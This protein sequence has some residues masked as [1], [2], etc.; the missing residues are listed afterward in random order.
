MNPL[1]I[2]LIAAAIV[3]VAAIVLYNWFQERK[4]RK[5]SREMFESQQ[6]VLLDEQPNAEYNAERIEPYL[7]ERPV[8]PAGF[9]PDTTSRLDTAVEHTAASVPQ[10]AMNYQ[11]DAPRVSQPAQ[12]SIKA[13]STQ[14][15]AASVVSAE[16]PP[17]P[18][19]PEIDFEIRIHTADA[20]PGSAMTQL[21]E[22][23]RS[24]GKPVY[25]LGYSHLAGAWEEIAGWREDAYTEIAIAVQLA[26]RNGAVS[27]EHLMQMCTLARQLASR[28]NGIAECPDISSALQRANELDLFC[29]DVDVLIGLN[30]VSRDN[31]VFAGSKISELAQ[32]ANMVLAVDGVYQ[33]RNADNEVIYSLCNHESAPFSANAGASFTTH[34]VTLLFDLPRVADGLAAFDRMVELALQLSEELGGQLVDDNIRRLTQA[35]IDKIRMQLD[36]IYQRMQARG[37]AGGSKRALRLFD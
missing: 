27:E 32:R 9:E 24:S 31:E 20:I 4:Y 14:K 11:P 10:P 15:H 33:C 30:V 16:L 19:D 22:S 13:E 28:F 1:Q 37:I 17:S 23:G 12:Q 8:D 26:D 7:D 34:G 6:D 18:A 35:G 3:V 36:Q 25:W 29:V 21:L 5:Q 2:S